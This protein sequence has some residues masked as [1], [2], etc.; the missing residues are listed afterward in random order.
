MNLRPAFAPKSSRFVSPSLKMSSIFPENPTELTA[1][2]IAPTG[3][4]DPLRYTSALIRAHSIYISK[5]YAYIY[6]LFRV[7]SSVFFN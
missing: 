7:L 2:E 4:F 5:I 3:Y 1:G 6:L